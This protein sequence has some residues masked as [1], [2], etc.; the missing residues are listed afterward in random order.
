MTRTS[1]V[2]FVGSAA[3]TVL[4]LGLAAPFPSVGAIVAVAGIVGL[5]GFLLYVFRFATTHGDQWVWQ[6]P[7]KPRREY[8]A[9][10]AAKP[11]S[12]STG[13]TPDAQAERPT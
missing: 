11:E 3:L 5:M 1:V 10:Q 2:W 4:G 6:T 12:E 9:E 8:L 7:G 13:T